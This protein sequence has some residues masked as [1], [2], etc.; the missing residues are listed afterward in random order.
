MSYE[1]VHLD[2]YYLRE[3]IESIL[4]KDSLDQISYTASVKITVPASMQVINPADIIRVSGVPYG[5][6]VWKPLLDPGVVWEVNSGTGDIKTLD[7]TIYDRTIYIAKSEDEYLF[8]AGQT[9]SQRLRKYAT[10]WGIKLST[11]PDTKTKLKKA[12]YRSQAIYNMITSDLQETVKAGGDMYI[13]RM[14]TTGLELFK[15]GSNSTVWVLEA[16]ESISRRRTLEGTITKVKVIGTEDRKK[17][18]RTKGSGSK[19]E[20]PSPILAIAT[21]ETEKY[22]TLQRMVQDEDVKTAAAG[23]KLAESM[24]TGIQETI[25]YTGLDINTLRAGDSVKL[26]G[27]EQIVTSIT[28]MLGDPGHMNLDLASVDYVKRRY[29]LKYG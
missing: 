7:L 6:N 16:T 23:K 14:T 25:S 17:T 29:F 11:I 22:G 8:P 18:V 21:G 28:H 20:S 15:V 5:Q 13:P 19:E 1:V 4:L 10:D 12:V 9:A 24:L 3:L 26:N 27:V 2:K